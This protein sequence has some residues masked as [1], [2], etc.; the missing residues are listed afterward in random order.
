MTKSDLLDRWHGNS[1]FPADR[2]VYNVGIIVFENRKN[3]ST[4]IYLD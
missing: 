1:A 3:I 2:H 4:V